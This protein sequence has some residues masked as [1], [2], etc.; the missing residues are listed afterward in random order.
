ME[1]RGVLNGD[2]V[3][4]DNGEYVITMGRDESEI[5][6]LQETTGIN[7]TF[8]VATALSS[9]FIWSVFIPCLEESLVNNKSKHYN[10][11]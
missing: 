5:Y 1:L 2:L 8:I 6:L 10:G 4:S 3:R 11:Y 9:H 7:M